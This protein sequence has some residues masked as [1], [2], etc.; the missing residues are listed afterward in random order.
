MK[1]QEVQ[2]R[3][4]EIRSLLLDLL[5]VE[6]VYTSR[7]TVVFRGQA[8]FPGP[9]CESEITTRLHGAGFGSSIET[10]TESMSL[11]GDVLV[12]IPL[13]AHSGKKI[14]LLNIVLFLATVASTT[15]FGGPAFAAWFMTILLFHE[16]GHFIM[17]RRRQ[18]D[19][20]WPFFIPAPNILGT[21]GA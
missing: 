13:A 8:R 9:D 4:E 5:Q 10:V 15:L 2:D 18:I 21:F 1:R 6:A 12:T 3:T 20:S 19:A 14:P 7:S 17:A 16:F 11:S